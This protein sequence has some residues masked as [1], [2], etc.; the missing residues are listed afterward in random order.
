[1][2][3]FGFDLVPGAGVFLGKEVEDGV[4]AFFDPLFF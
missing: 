1:V 3:K 2:G 4:L